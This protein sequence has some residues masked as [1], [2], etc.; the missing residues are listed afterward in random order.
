[1]RFPILINHDLIRNGPSFSIKTNTT[2]TRTSKTKTKD[3]IKTTDYWPMLMM[4]SMCPCYYRINITQM[5]ILIILLVDYNLTYV[6]PTI[7]D[8]VL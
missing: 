4:S 8:S 2:K 6:F 5:F 7:R 3:K 1:M